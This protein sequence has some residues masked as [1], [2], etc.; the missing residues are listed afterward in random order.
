MKSVVIKSV[1]VSHFY[2]YFS[3]LFTLINV[4]SACSMNF[5]KLKIDSRIDFLTCSVNFY[6]L[7]LVQEFIISPHNSCS[8]KNSSSHL[9]LLLF[10]RKTCIILVMKCSMRKQGTHIFGNRRTR[11]ICWFEITEWGLKLR[12]AVDSIGWLSREL[13]AGKEAIFEKEGWNTKARFRWTWTGF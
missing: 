6:E 5:K 10:N 8:W 2:D 3:Q 9:I 12:K 4:F 11:Q 1:N 7:K 13:K